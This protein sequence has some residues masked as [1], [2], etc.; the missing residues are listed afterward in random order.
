MNLSLRWKV[1]F[2]ILLSVGVA[3]TLAGWLILHLV[4][5]LTLETTAL[6]T[7]QFRAEVWVALGAAFAL[8]AGLSWAIA[9]SLTRPL[10]D[11][12]VLARQ[13]ATLL[14]LDHK[15]VIERKLKVLDD[16]KS[17]G[18]EKAE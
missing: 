15:D 6:T 12:A 1:T 9:W 14:R 18:E 8:A 16:V 4:S 10:A 7:D 17:R 2:G 3:L 13:L 11:M 5:Q